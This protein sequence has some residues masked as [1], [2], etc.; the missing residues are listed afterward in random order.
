MYDQ[1]KGKQPS[2]NCF[3]AICEIL[4]S[5]AKSAGIVPK[6]SYSPKRFWC[7]E[8]SQLRDRK[9]FW[10]RIWTA[11]GRP[12]DGAVFDCWKTAKKT[13]RRVCR[14]FVADTA[15][16]RIKELNSLFHGKR[17]AAFWK[18]LTRKNNFTQSSLPAQDLASAFSG[19]MSD[20]PTTLT[21]AQT[22]IC[23]LVNSC[24]QKS[25]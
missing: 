2:L 14:G 6:R 19:V 17:I 24:S 1:T 12:R 5:T 16:V 15:G 13:F 8:L 18:K 10:W 21:P 9:R 11:C 7:P 22:N 23:R 25:L 4:H 20:D 3:I